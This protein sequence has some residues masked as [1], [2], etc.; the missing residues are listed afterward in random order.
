M[1]FSSIEKRREANRKS[2]EKHKAARLARCAAYRA[3]NREAIKTKERKR[4]AVRTDYLSEWRNVMRFRRSLLNS[5][6]AARIGGYAPCTAT[7]KE[8]EAAFTGYCQHCGKKEGKRRLHMDHNHETGEFRGW[9][10]AN[11][12]RY[13]KLAVSLKAGKQ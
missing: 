3:A 6:R 1:P 5:K 7:T 4:N 9:L 12:N 13:D 8:I 2:Y 11:C 10:C